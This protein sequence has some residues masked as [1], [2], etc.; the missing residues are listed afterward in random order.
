MAKKNNLKSIY[1]SIYISIFILA[2]I[3]TIIIYNSSENQDN[4]SRKDMMNTIR[5]D[6]NPFYQ[7]SIKNIDSIKNGKPKKLLNFVEKI[8]GKV[9]ITD[10]KGNIYFTNNELITTE[11]VNL[12]EYLY[13]DANYAYQNEG[14]FKI[15]FPLIKNNNVL[16][17]LLIEF[18]QNYM[19]QFTKTNSNKIQLIIFYTTIIMLLLFFFI[20]NYKINKDFYKHINKLHNSLINVSKGIYKPLKINN[21]TLLPHI[22][23]SYNI[24]IEE[25]SYLMKQQQSNNGLRKQFFTMVSHELKTP[26]TSIIAYIEGLQKNVANDDETRQKY[27]D[28]IYD[29][30]NKMSLLINDLFKFSQQDINKFKI[31]LKEHYAYDSFQNLLLPIKEQL[32]NSN[33]KLSISNMLPNCLILMDEIRIEQVIQNIIN[34][35]IKHLNKKEGKINITALKQNKKINISISDNGEGINPKDLPYIF[36]YFYQG[37]HSKSDYEGVG[38]GLAICKEIIEKHGGMITV[39]S[40]QT[41]GTIFSFSLPII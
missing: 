11:N 19:Q 9:T 39:K 17:N 31:N 21:N 35:A 30:V 14:S 36:D 2:I 4:P 15:A 13:Y 25:L 33:I 29:K 22:Y 6:T 18:N 38:L 7:Y 28:I 34:N 12:M 32:N 3:G 10:P 37:N 23:E 27:I 1:I 20:L 24:M 41:T 16:G 8:D 5:V 26:L 40:S